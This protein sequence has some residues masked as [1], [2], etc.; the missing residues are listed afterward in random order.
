MKVLFATS[1]D[2]PTVVLSFGAG[3]DSWTLLLRS[4]H[5]L[6]FRAR[7]IGDAN[8]VCVFADTGNEWPETY[9]SLDDARALCAEYGV[10][11]A[12]L[13]GDSGYHSAGWANGIEGQMRDHSSIIMR[14]T[15]SCTAGTKVAPIYMYLDAFLAERYGLVGGRK[16]GLRGYTERFGRL[17]VMIGYAKGEERR[18]NK[19]SGAEQLSLPLDGTPAPQSALPPWMRDCIERFYPLIDLGMDRAACQAYCATHNRT[20]WPSNCQMCPHATPEDVLLLS[21]EE[22]ATFARWV[23]YEQAKIAKHDGRDKNHGV[24][25]ATTL[26]EVRDDCF[27]KYRDF[28]PDDLLRVLRERRFTRGH[29]VSSSH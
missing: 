11:F 10:T 24:F 19:A 12:W 29:C 2:K 27:A 1:P 17:R 20:I 18:A 8:L 28:A 4:C 16:R 21:L 5:D 15:R 22:P 13:R 26:G 23:A 3:Q 25:G 6:D 7:F 9:R 14:T